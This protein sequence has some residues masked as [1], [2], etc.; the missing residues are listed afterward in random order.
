MTRGDRVQRHVVETWIAGIIAA[1]WL[2]VLLNAADEVAQTV[3]NMGLAM[4]AF[5][6]AVGCGLAALRHRGRRRWVWTL[7]CLSAASWG[8]G[9]VVWAFY[10]FTGRELPYPSLADVGYLGAVPFAVAALLLLPTAADSAAGRIRTVIDGLMIA[11]SLL[12]FSWIV[13]LGQLFSAEESNWMTH[14]IGLAYPIG[15]IVLVTIV[16]YVMLRTRRAAGADMVPLGL[17]GFGIVCL[18]FADTAFVYLTTTDAYSSG[19]PIDAGW[20]IGYLLIFVASRRP[21][22]DRVIV[23]D[24]SYSSRR[25]GMLLPY[26][27]VVLALFTSVLELLRSGDVDPFVSWARSFIIAAMVIRQVLT[28][29]ENE[30]LTRHLEDRVH[31]LR[32]S[33]QR[34]E[35]LVQH[36]SDVVTVIDASSRVQYQA[37]ASTR[38]FGYTAEW[39]TGRHF[40]D[41]MEPETANELL[42]VLD[43][44][45][46]QP[47]GMSVV[48]LAIRHS[49]GRVVPVEMTITNLL[50]EP[51]VAGIVLN[52]RDISE[53]KALEDQLVHEAFHDSLTA[54]ANRALFT[55]RL[56]HAMCRPG[57]DP[58]SIAVLFLDLDGFKT[59]NDSLGHAS[60]DLLLT[61]V[62]ERLR[63]CVRP[64]DTVARLGGD[65]F[66]VLVENVT[67][68][69]D[70]LG[71]AERITGAFVEPF[72]VE[73]RSIQLSGSVGIARS[74]EN[75]AGADQLLRNA[76]LA[77]YRAKAIGGNRIEQYD[78]EM[79]VALVDRL[80]L[81]SE[82]AWALSS[83]QLTLHYQPTLSLETHEVVGVEALVRWEHPTRGT[84]P[85]LAFIPLAEETG[86][87]T[88]LGE[89]V[90]RE[91]CE[92]AAR[93]RA[94]EP[95]FE[96]VTMSVNLS[97]AQM[98]TD[99]PALVEEVLRETGLPGDALVLEMTESVL[100]DHTD[101]T[102]GI[103][104][105]I[106]DLGVSL[107]IDDFGTGDSSLSYLHR[108][109][110]DMLKI[111]RSFIARL[112]SADD[113]YELLHAI[114]HLARSMFMTTV[115][116]GIEE[117]EQLVRLQE[118]GCDLG[119]G[120]YFAKPAPADVIAA[121]LPRRRTRRPRAATTS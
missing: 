94:A 39:L 24:D 98:N 117:N 75:V 6:A 71:V 74:G 121:N 115:A 12:L 79:H 82:L 112:N 116:E 89:W 106:K 78:E 9:M 64:G 5:A 84:I 67:H 99:L 95:A 48:E 91:A 96:S 83:N 102:T 32:A 113:A 107:A 25:I 63:T 45:A 33:E 21:E 31:D 50:Q 28:L 19:N 38:V 30:K 58:D 88:Q 120:Y 49:N 85:P 14:A 36:S 60:G 2:V 73:G 86:L 22:A 52:T 16:L 61:E 7:L 65:E 108:F 92:Q 111:D 80:A 97:G 105:R 26:M 4:A 69:D 47:Y 59:I 43:Q 20:F 68:L 3:S 11:G 66:A 104:T 23:A 1:I 13:I 62:A 8:S 101:E 18:S 72:V 109:P 41:L 35:A 100:I 76:D 87:I 55:D 53:R 70:A 51:S 57:V 81:E 15:D 103:L 114:V 90:L 10:E 77:M 17:I 29:F 27:A 46:R 34:F 110:V 42:E 119:Q 54:L 37:E 118:L 44:V 56:D 93:W 40:I